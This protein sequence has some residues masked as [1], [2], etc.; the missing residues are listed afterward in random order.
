MGNGPSSQLDSDD[1]E[2]AP[3]PPSAAVHVSEDYKIVT[4]MRAALEELLSHRSNVLTP[5][6]RQLLAHIRQYLIERHYHRDKFNNWD[7]A[8]VNAARESSYRQMKPLELLH[9]IDVLFDLLQ[10]EQ[11]LRPGFKA[12]LKHWPHGPPSPPKPH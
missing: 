5:N 11:H 6:A 10:D 8:D 12:F 3:P 7:D 4:H 1:E 2:D 9:R